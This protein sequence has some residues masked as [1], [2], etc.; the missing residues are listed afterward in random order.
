LLDL[1]FT[2]GEYTLVSMALSTLGVALDD[3]LEGFPK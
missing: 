3:G 1:V 2:I